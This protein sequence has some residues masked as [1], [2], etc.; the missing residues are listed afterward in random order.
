MTA[1]GDVLD[2][3]RSGDLGGAARLYRRVLGMTP[4]D[5]EVLHVGGLLALRQQQPADAEAWLARAV[6]V[7]PDIAVVH[8]NLAVARRAIGR[9]DDGHR[10]LRHA[11]ALDPGRAEFAYNQANLFKAQAL[12]EQARRWYEVAL[13]LDSTQPKFHYNLGNLLFHCGELN[14]SALHLNAA[15]RLSEERSVDAAVNLGMALQKQNRIDRA[16]SWYDR[17]LSLDPGSAAAHLN[18]AM[19]LLVTGRL[20]EGWREYGWR[21]R[22]SNAPPPGCG[23]PKWT[24]EPLPQGTILLYA[25]QGLGDTIQ[26]IRYVPMVAERCHHVVV[27]CQPPLCTLVAGSYPSATVLADGSLLPPFDV[28]AGLIDLPG[29]LGTTL[30]NI[31]ASV[32][33][34]RTPEV[35]RPA[36]QGGLSVGFIWAG[37]AEHRNDRRRSLDVRLLRPLF[38]IPGVRAHSLQVGPRAMEL[39]RLGDRHG[40]IDLAAGIEA[41]TDTAEQLLRLDLLISVDTSAAHLAG[42]LG[43]PVWILLPF[44]PDWRWL[45]DRTDT[46]WYPSALLFRQDRPDDWSGPLDRLAER[47]RKAVSNPALLNPEITA[48]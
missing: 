39:G 29:L 26:F 23:G 19:S 41:F 5:P 16:M 3:I 6:R 13:V 35:V 8:A 2:L 10:A 37:S 4:A 14:E 38:D 47:L 27:V 9:L 1:A 46:P 12:E 31:P 44:S 33:Y 25:E 42:A 40:V 34:L 48:A 32:P 11:L 45:L 7:R 36:G 28:C 20:E 24:G 22:V 18:R 15:W 43:R 30:E 21:W 17:A